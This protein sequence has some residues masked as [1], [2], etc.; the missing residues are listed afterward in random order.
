MNNV[1]SNF[2]LNIDETTS[3]E[4]Q[5]TIV[6]TTTQIPQGLLIIIISNNKVI[7]R[8][9]YINRTNDKSINDDN[10]KNHSH[11]PK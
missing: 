3:T 2:I 8:T 6:P 5:S 1:Y 7:C 10:F 11:Q 4:V 9:K